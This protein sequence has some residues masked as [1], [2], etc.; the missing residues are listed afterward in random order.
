MM[1]FIL[2][3]VELMAMRFSHPSRT[4][5]HTHTHDAEQLQS[6]SLSSLPLK[7][8]AERLPDHPS[9]HTPGNDH[10][11]HTHSHSDLDLNSASSST[12]HRTKDYAA[13]MTAIFILEFGVIF[14]SV[15]VGLTLAVA[16]TEFT[17]LYV[18]LA[19]HQTFEGLGLGSRL[20]V[21]PFPPSKKWTPYYMAVGYAVTT[22]ISIAVGLAFRGTY[23]PG[24]ETALVVNGVF[25]AVSAGILIYTGLVELMAHEFMFS[26]VMRGAELRVVLAAFAMMC[27][28]AGES[29][30]SLFPPTQPVLAFSVVVVWGGGGLYWVFW[31]GIG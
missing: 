26:E 25:D 20:A 7:S 15:F 3:F 6:D 5:S 12:D 13:Q 16:G 31:D 11:G 2:F 21:A 27:L 24:S 28:G 23:A 14:H 1:I 18:V 22:P 17:I 19:F 4:H 9:G 29:C 30:S 10:L 8:E